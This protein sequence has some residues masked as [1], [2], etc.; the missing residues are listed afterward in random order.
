MNVKIF[1]QITEIT[2]SASISV[3]GAEDTDAL[4]KK[5]HKLYPSLSGSKYAIAVNKKIIRNNT[6]LDD[7]SEVALLP[8]FSG[9]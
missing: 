1:G 6:A 5:M 2:G 4:M 3:N 8:P 9:G 7:D